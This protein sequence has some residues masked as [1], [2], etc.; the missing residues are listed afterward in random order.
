[1]TKSTET[2][3]PAFAAA[4]FPM[5]A[6]GQKMMHAAAR[7]N[8]QMFTAMMRY[9]S[10]TLDFLK[11]RYEQDL[12]LVDDLAASEETG[13]AFDVLSVFWRNAASEYAIEAGRVARIGSKIAAETAGQVREE[14]EMA[15][16]DM[17]AQTVA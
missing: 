6:Q 16:K 5:A 4:S 3:S 14:A 13:D 17:A 1:M 11:R 7:N 8:A 9:Q 12:K 15:V 2:Y 10:E